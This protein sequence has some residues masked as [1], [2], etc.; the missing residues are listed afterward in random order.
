MQIFLSSSCRWLLLKTATP[1][2]FICGEFRPQNIPFPFFVSDESGTADTDRALSSS[3]APTITKTSAPSSG[4]SSQA[5]TTTRRRKLRTERRST[6]I[7]NLDVSTT[8]RLADDDDDENYT[9]LV[10]R[11]NQRLGRKTAPAQSLLIPKPH[12][13]FSNLEAEPQRPVPK[14]Q[15]TPKFS[16]VAA[17]S[18]A[19]EPSRKAEDSSVKN[20][21]R[22]QS[23]RCKPKP[24][25]VKLPPAPLEH[26]TERNS[27]KVI[28]EAVA[29]KR[30]AATYRKSPADDELFG[31]RVGGG[32]SLVSLMSNLPDE[33]QPR[34]SRL[35]VNNNNNDS[36]DSAAP[37]HR[38]PL[39]PIA[40]PQTVSDPVNYMLAALFVAALMLIG[41]LFR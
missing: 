27:E 29:D 15:P 5:A 37:S 2:V 16:R 4:G 14:P 30:R 20:S 35:S 22:E 12:S 32:G 26:A 38:H 31:E 25:T 11:L 33:H 1:T 17:P 21:N 40:Q 6:G 7:Q 41:N 34:I 19:T 28:G 13:K 18:I 3:S 39:A 24:I 8:T 10:T 23:S 36:L 9:Q